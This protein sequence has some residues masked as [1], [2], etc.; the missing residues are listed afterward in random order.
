MFL[1]SLQFLPL[2][3][4]GASIEDAKLINKLYFLG[5]AITTV[6][7][8]SRQE[9]IYKPETVSKKSALGAPI[10]A[11]FAIGFLYLL[12]KFGL[13][14]TSVY[15]ILVSI[16]GVLSISDIGVPLL[17]NVLEPF[18]K[19]A[20]LGF[21]TAQIKVPQ[22]LSEVFGSN[23]EDPPDTI[24]VERVSA[25]A[26][27]VL[28]TAIYWAPSLAM[29]QKFLVSNLIAWSIGMASL[30]VISLGTFQTGA[31]LLGGLFFYDI[32]FVFGTDVMMTVALK[33]EAPVK[34]LYPAPPSDVPR[35]YPFS[36]LG[37]G[38]VVIPGIFVRFM[39]KLDA[40][41]QPT[42]LSYATTTTIAY[43]VGLLVCFVANE[44]TNSGQPALLYLNPACVGSAIACG[45]AN[46]Q[47]Q[48]VWNFEDETATSSSRYDRKTNST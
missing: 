6:Y 17:R 5:T 29:E 11:S 27:G 4:N 34:F 10:G 42:R 18:E 30:G 45:A 28:A 25:V 12:I 47:L 23:P 35:E 41:L 32:F 16:Y 24:P 19:I 37:L 9:T 22:Q 33:I 3:D 44:L 21:A 46:G 31:I 26:L 8:G 15:A 20:N 2:I 40:S 1:L 48:E 7:L 36:V 43:G 14:P 13:D 38:D 39:T